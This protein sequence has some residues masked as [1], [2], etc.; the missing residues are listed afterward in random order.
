VH[1]FINPIVARI[2]ELETQLIESDDFLKVLSD[3]EEFLKSI[4]SETQ[5]AKSVQEYKQEAVQM[6]LVARSQYEN[7]LLKLEN[8]LFNNEVIM[9]SIHANSSDLQKI[10]RA[11]CGTT[12]TAT[13]RMPSSA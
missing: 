5:E 9:T 4:K 10:G 7:N 3:K 11:H 12:V 8:S 13:S 1:E 6:I 2:A